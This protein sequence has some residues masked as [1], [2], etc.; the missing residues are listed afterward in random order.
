[1]T[2]VVAYFSGPAAA[3]S[4]AS[5]HDV[6]D[7]RFDGLADFSGLLAQGF[8]LAAQIPKPLDAFGLGV[9]PHRQ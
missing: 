1:V 3:V 9:F 5:R 2:S 8:E 6:P 7:L 4:L